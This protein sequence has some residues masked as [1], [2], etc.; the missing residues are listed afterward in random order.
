MIIAATIII[1]IVLCA[2]LLVVATKPPPPSPSPSHAPPPPESAI[3]FYVPQEEPHVFKNP[4][5]GSPTQCEP[6]SKPMSSALPFANV[7]M[8]YAC[9]KPI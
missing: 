2:M 4:R 9:E 7:P 1:V 3:D 5:G 6:I 8:A